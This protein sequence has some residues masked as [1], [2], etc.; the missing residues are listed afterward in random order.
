VKRKDQQQEDQPDH[1]P[2]IGSSRIKFTVGQQ[3]KK[4][5]HYRDQKKIELFAI[6]GL[7][8]QKG[9]QKGISFLIGSSE[10]GR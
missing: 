2:K 1:I 4:S 5:D 10:D 9:L 6:I 8:G 3:N 7:K